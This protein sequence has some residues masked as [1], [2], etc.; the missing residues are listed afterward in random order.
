[1]HKGN[2]RHRV[3]SAGAAALCIISSLLVL[4]A[5]ANPLVSTGF[6]DDRLLVK[7]GPDVG[8]LERQQLA[9]TLGIR[10]VGEL[11]Q[12]DVYL[13]S[14]PRGKVFE[15]Q[16]QLEAHPSIVYAEPDWVAESLGTP[17]DTHWGIQWGPERILAP[18]A[19]DISP[20]TFEG[21]GSSATGV[22]IA[23]VD[24]GILATHEDLDDGRVDTGRGANCLSGTCVS[25]PA[26]DD[27]G[28]G[29]HVAGILGAETNNLKGIAGIAFN[30]RLIPV[31]VLDS[32]GNG[33][34]SAVA[35]GILWAAEHG[36]KVINLSLGGQQAGTTLCSAI[37]TAAQTY[38]SIS[39]AAAGNAGG[40]PITYPA[41]CD[42]ALAIGSTDQTDN[43]SSFSD[44]GPQLFTTAP[45]SDV[46]STLPTC[47][48][49]LS[50]STGYGSLHGTSMAT[51]HVSGLIALVAFARRGAS[52]SLV[53]IKTALAA[54][55]DKVGPLSY[56]SD[57]RALPCATSCTWN[58][59]YGYGRINAL[60]AVR[61]NP[62]PDFWLAISP[63]SQ[64][65]EQG[66]SASYPITVNRR[67]GFSDP[68]TLSAH[69]LPSGASHT[70][71][72]N[73][74]T[75]TSSVL[76]VTTDPSVAAGSY[77]FTVSGAGGS[78]TRSVAARLTVTPS[79]FTV[80][81]GPSGRDV[82]QGGSVTYQVTI[83]RVGSFTE[84]IS[85][86]ISGLPSGA[87]G[88]FSPGQVTGESSI[89]TV[90]TSESTPLGTTSLSISGSAGNLVRTASPVTLTVHL[91]DS[92]LPAVQIDGAFV[93]TSVD[94]VL[95]GSASDNISVVRVVVHFY[96]AIG[97][98]IPIVA[99][100]VCP[101]SS[102]IWS[103]D[104]KSLPPGS[105][106]VKAVAYDVL[107][108]YSYSNAVQVL[109]V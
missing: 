101:G 48:S 96:P 102:V 41:A 39:V 86:S 91:P 88:S 35:A 83:S 21:Q 11:P 8:D 19:W 94:L 33:Y 43:R 59:E 9:A 23:V 24:S 98:D 81:V 55:A 28:H 18:Q 77:D 63:S 62:V 30:S 53:D 99:T 78:L 47:C 85:L 1:M 103:V 13:A 31:K 34:Y 56:G 27:S 3:I 64:S 32:S 50:S 71:S 52:T 109:V 6:K 22:D 46:Y 2:R 70:F 20:A 7:F 17:S 80:S 67:S 82:A 60:E 4:S 45:G 87:S 89:L 106:G 10:L 25:D 90:S 5:V 76:T 40:K 15:K 108:N 37:A 107:G 36:A 100:C 57:P 49:G 61:W 84:S 95:S 69:G 42:Q 65:A 66:K 16:V 14:L 44:F 68:I 51:S 72:A 26:T 29:T 93:Q 79:D 73:V 92:E 105:Y 75:G 97:G 12:I 74:V 58:E 104:D 38:G 54:T